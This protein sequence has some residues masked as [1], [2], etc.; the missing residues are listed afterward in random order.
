ALVPA[1]AGLG[2]QYARATTN[3]DIAAEKEVLELVHRPRDAGKRGS[4]THLCVRD[5]P[6]R[7]SKVA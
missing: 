1:D 5:V 2:P 3:A 7:V 6:G 4:R